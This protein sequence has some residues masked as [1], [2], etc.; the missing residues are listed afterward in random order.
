M[1]LEAIS[2]TRAPCFI[3]GSKHLVTITALRLRRQT[4]IFFSV[5]E[6]PD[7]TLTL[8]DMFHPLYR[9]SVSSAAFRN[10]IAKTSLFFN[11]YVRVSNDVPSRPSGLGFHVLNL[12]F[13]TKSP[14]SRFSFF[15]HPR[16][17]K[18]TL[19]NT[20]S[21]FACVWPPVSNS[22][23]VMFSS[24][25]RLWFRAFCME[26][27]IPNQNFCS[28]ALSLLLLVTNCESSW[29]CHLTLVET[30]PQ[31]HSLFFQRVSNDTTLMATLMVV[32]ASR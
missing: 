12:E 26:R 31:R 18:S 6:T 1:V 11:D 8:V 23:S 30:T 13:Q 16:T 2:K 9:K 10:Q 4:V 28:Q 29:T 24:C 19:K 25:C 27:E 21:F 3:R 14:T 20:L 32:L 7:E 5:F 22:T 17:N 15:D